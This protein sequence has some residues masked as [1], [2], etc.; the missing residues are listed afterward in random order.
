MILMSLFNICFFLN[1]FKILYHSIKYTKV[2]A[3]AK[4]GMLYPKNSR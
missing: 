4:V 3:M 1:T 2:T